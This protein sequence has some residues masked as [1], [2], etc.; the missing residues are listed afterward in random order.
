MYYID[1]LAGVHRQL[2]PP[3]YL[4]IGIRD[5]KS[6]A[7]SRARSIAIDPAFAVTHELHCDVSLHRTT[8]DDYFAAPQAWSHFDGR[9]AALSFIDGMHLFE[10]ALRDFVNV[11]RGSAWHSVVVFDDVMPR[12]PQEAARDRSTVAWTGDVYK[13]W[14]AL[15]QRRPDLRLVPVH[16]APTGLLV[17]LGADPQSRTLAASLD[18]ALA[19]QGLD[20]RTVPDQVLNRE[21]AVDPQRLLD[22]GLFTM[23]RTARETDEPAEPG[24]D[25]LYAFMDDIEPGLRVDWST[26]SLTRPPLKRWSPPTARSPR[27]ALTRHVRR[28]ARRLGGR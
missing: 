24:R 25:K 27:A 3:T 19:E 13:V 10:F 26:T 8:S 1:F 14:L 6:L 21:H 12:R 2:Q 4:E 28:A 7:L 5:G 23:L 20:D 18:D 16:T 17:V 15:R 9:P 11:E 22:S